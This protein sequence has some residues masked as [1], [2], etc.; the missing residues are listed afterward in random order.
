MTTHPLVVWQLSDGKRGHERQAQGLIE[1]LGTQTRLEKRLVPVRLLP[2]TLGL[3]ALLRRAP[4]APLLPPPDVLV[5]AGRRTHWPAVWLRRIFRCRSICLMRP[6]ASRPWFDLSIVPQHDEPPTASNIIVSEGPLNPFH[7]GPAQQALGLVLLGGPSR[8][9]AWDATT[10]LRQLS[11]VLKRTEG[12][13]WIICTSRR[14]P[15]DFED[16]L[17]AWNFPRARVMPFDAADENWLVR[18]LPAAQ[19]I[20]VSAD[21]LSMIYEALTVTT[22][23]GVL[24]LPERRQDRV[25]RAVGNLIASAKVRTADAPTQLMT[26]EPLAEASRCAGLV[27]Q[28]WPDLR[29]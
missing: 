22:S 4:A 1:A 3:D 27:L 19:E 7:P 17:A 6:G 13:D 26:H 14:T 25:S 12:K 11:A 21:S 8:H 15:P 18:H 16:E 29:R 10:L 2:G 28:R 5:A 23:V 9:H 24:T 20:W